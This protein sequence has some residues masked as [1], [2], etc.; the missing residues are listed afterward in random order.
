MSRFKRSG[1]RDPSTAS[2]H[3]ALYTVCDLL[4][5]GSLGVFVA[6]M[7]PLL[8]GH[9]LPMFPRMVLAM[10][11]GMILATPLTVLASIPLGMFETMP[12]G[13]WTGMLA[14]MLGVMDP[15]GKAVKIKEGLMAGATVWL[16]FSLLNAYYRSKRAESL[17]SLTLTDKS[18]GK[19]DCASRAAFWDRFAA[20]Y[21]VFL[22]GSERRQR[23]AK[24]QAFSHAGGRVLFVGAGTGTD[25]LL[26]PPDIDL[27]AV[28][29]SKKMLEKAK[30]RAQA[31]GGTVHLIQADIEHSPFPVSSFDSIVTSCVFCSVPDPVKGLKE[32]RRILKPG[33]KL[34]MFEHVLS[35][36]PLLASMLKVMNYFS[37]GPD[38]TRDTVG[39]VLRAGL[40]PVTHKNI[41][42]DIVKAIKVKNGIA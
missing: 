7:V 25:L 39:N 28:D 18:P 22:W 34:I 10:A 27:F 20:V 13:M 31:H 17:D 6:S 12:Y 40:A 35:R 23:D 8:P 37:A 3:P 21:D 16:C 2:F 32:V 5:V 38:M 24:R 33:G 14:A 26:M 4:F 9:S 15:D 41:Y 42:M 30:K 1:W 11:V 36:N 19:K 29:I